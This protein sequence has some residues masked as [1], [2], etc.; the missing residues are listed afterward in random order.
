MPQ[1]RRYHSASV[2][3]GRLL[4]FGGQY[5][6]IDADLHFECDNAVAIYDVAECTWSAMPID[7]TT[8]LRRACH[9]A[10]VVGKRVFVVGGR[11]W[12]VAE[13]DYIFLN[14]IQILHTEPPSTLA[15]D[16]GKF[17]DNPHLSDIIIVAEGREVH[18]H[19]VVLAARCQYF[20]GMFESGMRE[21][22]QHTVTLD[23]ISY[24]VLM[25][26]LEHLYTDTINLTPELALPLFA[27]AD[28][29]GV[30]Q[31][32]RRRTEPL[33]SRPLP[34]LWLPCIVCTGP[35]SAS[36]ARMALP[37]RARVSAHASATAEGWSR[38]GDRWVGS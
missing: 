28:F 13:D 22:G 17:I 19:R 26:M 37:K 1:E 34:R 27:A 14:D 3:D 10:G 16:W 20:R 24:T 32:C 2:V 21:V 9:A 18:A 7:A 4:I 15:L 8:P 35:A 31:V 12:D 23:N 30:E 5:Y 38:L 6:D 33:K 29:L 11:Y 36:H 25:A